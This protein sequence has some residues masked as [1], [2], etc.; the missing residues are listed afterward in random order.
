MVTHPG[1]NLEL[2]DHNIPFVIHFKTGLALRQVATELLAA[3][4]LH[5]Q[6]ALQ[7]HVLLADLPLFLRKLCH[8]L[9]V[10]NTKQ[11]NKPVGVQPSTAAGNVTLLASATG[12]EPRSNRSISPACLAHSSKPAAWL[13]QRSMV[14]QT[15][16]VPLHRC[17]RIPR[18]QH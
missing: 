15:D 5:L 4:N 9:L 17:C 11:T 13:L 10:Y 2:A 6:L 3:L 12:R 1:T 7:S 16:T 18:E 8:L 14:G